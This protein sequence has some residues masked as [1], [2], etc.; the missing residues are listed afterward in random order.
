MDGAAMINSKHREQIQRRVACAVLLSLVRH[1]QWCSLIM[2][3][4]L[5]SVT[6][7][8]RNNTYYIIHIHSGRKGIILTDVQQSMSAAELERD[9]FL[10][11][12]FAMHSQR[13]RRPTCMRKANSVS[14]VLHA[15]GVCTRVDNHES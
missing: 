6:L 12:Q 5:G 3:F 1:N 10:N 15:N 7:G 2:H 13:R 11:Q 9:A 8:T 14:A 4:G